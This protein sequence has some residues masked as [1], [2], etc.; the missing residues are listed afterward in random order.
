VVPEGIEELA[1]VKESRRFEPLLVV[2]V[3]DQV[4][5]GEKPLDVP[6]LKPVRVRKSAKL[7]SVVGPDSDRL[8]SAQAHH[9][10]G[11][12]Q[13]RDNSWQ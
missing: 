4:A 12:R 9:I 6:V 3:T 8:L 13:H 2:P 11:T 10:G 7:E 5:S 1:V